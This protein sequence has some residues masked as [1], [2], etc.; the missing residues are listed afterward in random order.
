M[1]SS[2]VPRW[3][4]IAH[5]L[6]KHLAIGGG[7][8]I[9]TSDKTSQYFLSASAKQRFQLSASSMGARRLLLF[10]TIIPRQDASADATV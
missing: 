3:T 5:A 4:A 9:R 8:P 2:E 10:R 7:R 1:A 6:E